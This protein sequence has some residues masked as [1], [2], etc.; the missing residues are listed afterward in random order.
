MGMMVVCWVAVCYS[1]FLFVFF[2]KYLPA[3]IYMVSIVSGLSCFGYLLQGPITRKYD[4]KITQ[5]ISF[6][7]VTACLIIVTLVGSFLNTLVYSVFILI[8]KFF[9]CLAFG[10]VYV[11]HLDLFD[12]S[13]LGTSY[14]ICNVVSRLAMI[15][16]PMVAEL[17]NKSIPMLI[18]LGMNICASVATW[19]LKKQK[20]L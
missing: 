17:E 18:L 11:I 8:L 14:G 20:P 9:V 4:I 7:L 12:S 6:G 13:F 15:S 2:I 3:D 1:Y 19:F 10:T 16:A 5:L